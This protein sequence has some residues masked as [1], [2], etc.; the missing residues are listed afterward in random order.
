MR[1]AEQLANSSRFQGHSLLQCPAKQIHVQTCLSSH[2][3]SFWGLG[4]LG[5][6]PIVEWAISVLVMIG[7]CLQR[8]YPICSSKRPMQS[9]PPR[10]SPPNSLKMPPSL[11]MLKV[12]SLATE[13]VQK[14]EGKKTATFLPC[15][16]QNALLNNT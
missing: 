11:G 14:K 13:L 12:R 3:K 15:L 7:S 10:M 5:G 2:A 8:N 1:S 16:L 6:N 4:G 9:L